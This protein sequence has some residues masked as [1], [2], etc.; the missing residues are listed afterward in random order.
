MAA[1]SDESSKATHCRNCG[2][3]ILGAFCQN[4][5]QKHLSS[6]LDAGDIASELLD[7]V[8]RL[9]SRLWRTVVGLTKNPGQVAADY[10]QGKRARYVNPVRYCFACVA[11]SIAAMLATGELEAFGQNLLQLSGAESQNQKV[12]QF[13]AA[14]TQYLNVMSLLSVPIFAFAVR[15]LFWTSGRNYAECLSFSCF[16]LGHG[17][18]LGVLA[19]L[20]NTYV[21]F[22]GIWPSAVINTVIP[23]YASIVFFQRGFVAVCFLV[24]LAFCAYLLVPMAASL[25]LLP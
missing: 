3:E 4:C 12:D 25:V 21:Y 19:T 18:L 8:V 24:S 17:A 2:T 9:D 10:A 13:F 15:W 5:G 22:L 23:I 20:F 16:V 1:T 6:G 14:F 11:L 7:S